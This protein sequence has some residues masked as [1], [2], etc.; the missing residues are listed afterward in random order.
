MGYLCRIP[1]NYDF[2]ATQLRVL[3]YFH[4]GSPASLNKHPK[5][6]NRN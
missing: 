2:T 4:T 5:G 1:V 3:V 6:Y